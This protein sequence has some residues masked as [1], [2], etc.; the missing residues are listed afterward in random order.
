M[1][2]KRAGGVDKDLDLFWYPERGEYFRNERRVV[3]GKECFKGR[4]VTP[5]ELNQP[6]IGALD[7]RV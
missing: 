1:A 7:E 4:W 2:R 3:D 5:E 6:P